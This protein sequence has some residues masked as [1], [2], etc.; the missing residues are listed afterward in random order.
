[1][2]DTIKGFSSGYDTD[3]PRRYLRARKFDP[4]EAFNQFKDT[5]DWRKENQ[6]DKVYETIDVEEYDQSRR[7][8][9]ETHG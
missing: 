3:S 5:E 1:M 6:I 2:R 4:T 7:L 9:G 8:V